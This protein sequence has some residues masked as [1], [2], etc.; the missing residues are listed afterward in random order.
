MTSKRITDNLDAML[1]VLPPHL[2]QELMRINRSDEL[3]EVILAPYATVAM[4]DARLTV[5]A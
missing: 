3:L 5:G 4:I 1:G 2:S